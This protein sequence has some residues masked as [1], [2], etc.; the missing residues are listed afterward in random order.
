[1]ALREHSNRQVRASSFSWR[2]GLR[3]LLVAVLVVAVATVLLSN[4]RDLLIPIIPTTAQSGYQVDGNELLIEPPPGSRL[5][6]EFWLSGRR[7][8]CGAVRWC[9]GNLVC[10]LVRRAFTLDKT[11]TTRGVVGFAVW[12]IVRDASPRRYV[13]ADAIG[14]LRPLLSDARI[15][16]VWQ[17]PCSSDL[18]Y[19][20]QGLSYPAV[21]YLEATSPFAQ[22]NHAD[23]DTDSQTTVGQTVGI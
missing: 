3:R 23:V 11:D 10:K 6:L 22:R 15:L 16:S 2:F 14:T 18:W 8:P 19:R 20:G 13:Q 21:Q 12:L 5:F 9:S 1:M 7:L 4:W 17:M